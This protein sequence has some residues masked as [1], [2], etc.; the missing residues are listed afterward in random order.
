[1]L[2]SNL[3]VLPRPTVLSRRNCPPIRLTKCREIVSPSPVPPYLRVVDESTCVKLAN[4]VSCFSIGTPMPVSSTEIRN[5]IESASCDIRSTR[6]AIPPHSVNLMAFPT[7]FN[8]ICL[9]LVGSPRTREATEVDTLPIRL[10]PFSSARMEYKS[11]VS[12]TTV[13]RSNSVL[14]SV[15]KPASIFD[16]S[17]M[18]LTRLCRASPALRNT[19]T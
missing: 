17:R 5:P 18:S 3:N 2:I 8:K 19:E 11:T 1:M 7:R 13:R 16:R 15:S 14:S 12:A 4:I 10:N 9:S 6:S